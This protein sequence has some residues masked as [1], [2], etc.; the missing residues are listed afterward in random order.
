MPADQETVESDLYLSV[1]VLT[2]SSHPSEPCSSLRTSMQGYVECWQ[3][4]VAPNPVLRVSRVW[5]G[6]KEGRWP[7]GEAVLDGAQLVRMCRRIP[8]RK[9]MLGGVDG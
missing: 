1:N 9:D 5:S 3:G 8:T 2:M 4:T 7:T 6:D